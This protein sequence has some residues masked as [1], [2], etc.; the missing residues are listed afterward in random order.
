M[1]D[2][3]RRNRLLNFRDSRRSILLACPDLASVEDALAAG[4]EF[5]V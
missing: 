4:D 2:L 5:T 1:L 3:S